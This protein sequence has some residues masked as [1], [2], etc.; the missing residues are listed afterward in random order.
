MTAEKDNLGTF[1]ALLLLG[2][3][4]VAFFGGYMAGSKKV[5]KQP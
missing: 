5:D 2:L 3:V 1:Y 4:I